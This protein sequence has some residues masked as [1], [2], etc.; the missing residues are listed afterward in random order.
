[1][2]G[3]STTVQASQPTAE[4]TAIQRQQLELMQK[5]A[6]M[7]DSL[8]PFMLESSGIEVDPETGEYRRTAP[9]ELTQLLE[10]KALAAAKGELPLSSLVTQQLA[11]QERVLEEN[12]SRRLGPNWRETTPGIQALSEFQ[13]RKGILTD[14][15][16]R[17]E[18][19][20]STSLLG[21]REGLVSGLGGQFTSNVT[22][23]FSGLGTTAGQ[24]GGLLQPYQN[25]RAME[26]QAAQ[27]TAQN[28][29]SRDAALMGMIGTIGGVATGY[30]MR[31]ST[32]KPA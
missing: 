19:S 11:D 26:F 30:A 22:G 20:A 9:D 6:S 8:M 28:K 10:A 13:Q 31:P 32:P 16:Q 21:S 15:L 23:A 25:Q 24:F 7:Q 1:M 27:A 17:G 5:Q 29:A 14:E 2:C 18:T 4:E 12:L 3:G